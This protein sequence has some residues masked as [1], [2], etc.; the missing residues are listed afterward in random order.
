MPFPPTAFYGGIVP[1]SAILRT[2][3]TVETAEMEKNVPRVTQRIINGGNG[4]MIRQKNC[5]MSRK[6]LLFFLIWH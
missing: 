1:K 5:K 6:G 4:G 2:S 3:E